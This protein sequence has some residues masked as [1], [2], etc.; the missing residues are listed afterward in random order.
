MWRSTVTKNLLSFYGWC[1][2]FAGMMPEHTQYLPEL[3][4][5]R[6]AYSAEIFTAQDI[7][8]NPAVKYFSIS[9]SFGFRAFDPLEIS[10][11]LIA[12]ELKKRG[13]DQTEFGESNYGFV[14]EY[15]MIHGTYLGH[16]EVSHF[17]SLLIRIDL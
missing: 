11:N 3:R 2:R 9:D 12:G 17:E 13:L 1:A 6:S 8:D 15:S 5:D 14:P 4:I 7:V 16:L 10:R